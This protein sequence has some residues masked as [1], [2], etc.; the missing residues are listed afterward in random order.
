MHH[1]DYVILG[2]GVAGL[3]A[4]K[5]LL[6]LGYYPLVIEA[7]SYPAHKVCGEFLSPS[8]LPILEKWNIHP[9]PITQLQWHTSSQNLQMIFPQPAGSLSHFTLDFQ[10]ANQ[11]SQQ[12]ATLFTHTK[13]LDCSPP[14]RERECHH[15]S[16]SSGENISA[17]HLLI[18]AGRLPRYSSAA[19]SPRYIGLKAHFSGLELNSTLH[20]FSFQGAYLGI[21][22]V[23][24][25]RA[26]FACLAKIEQVQPFSSSQQFIE[27]LISSHPLLR[28]LLASGCHLFDCW[29]EAFVP[30]FGLRS[31]PNWPQTY[32]IGD[33]AGTIPPACGNGLSLAIASGYLAAE[34][35]TR[36]EA[37]GF[38]RAWI[39]R[40]AS[41]I[42]LAKGLHHLFLNPAWGSAAI[43]LNHWF[44]FM[45]QKIF[46]LT[47]D[48]G[49]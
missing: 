12:G 36:H 10:L 15:L 27:S 5:R 8:S 30:E 19:F 22:P 44:P 37:L 45:A 1:F 42:R 23:E 48:P 43:S 21:S 20:M 41:S 24:N 13:V 49:L 33:A 25:G 26:N 29:M 35:A 4:A 39:K 14:S 40:C 46:D 47:R 2:G 32:W 31:T 38:K 34:F 16:L 7:G 17:K 9:I 6:E 11:I 18:A 3:C 28:H